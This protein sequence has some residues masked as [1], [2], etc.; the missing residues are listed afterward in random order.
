[1]WKSLGLTALKNHQYIRLN[2]VIL[3]KTIREFIT[4]LFTTKQVTFGE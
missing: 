3:F 2:I 1:M 4:I